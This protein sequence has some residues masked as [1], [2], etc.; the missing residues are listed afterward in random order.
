MIGKVKSLVELRHAIH[1]GSA[2]FLQSLEHRSAAIQTEFQHPTSL[3][4]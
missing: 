3:L 4:T 2:Q 1:E